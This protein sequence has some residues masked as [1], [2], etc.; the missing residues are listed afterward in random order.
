[1]MTTALVFPAL[2]CSELIDL[3]RMINHSLSSTAI[4]FNNLLGV[5]S[6]DAGCRG[7]FVSELVFGM[8]FEFKYSINPRTS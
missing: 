2:T 1:M 6:G 7:S 8:A 3:C 5:E 4:V